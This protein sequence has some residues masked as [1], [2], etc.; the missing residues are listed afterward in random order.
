MGHYLALFVLWATL[1]NLTLEFQM[2]EQEMKEMK[3]KFCGS[4]LSEML[5]IVCNGVYNN[6]Q[7]KNNMYSRNELSNRDDYQEI[8]PIEYSD[9]PILSF[10]FRS[11][12]RAKSIIPVE[13]RKRSRGVASECCHKSCS[14]WEM[15]GYCGEQ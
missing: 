15:A 8:E 5:S 2:T 1:M 4:H 9:E 7:K 3:G 13:F 6:R 14:L 10:P 12:L 11:K